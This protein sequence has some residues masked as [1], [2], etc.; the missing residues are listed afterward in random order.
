MERALKGR[1]P[2]G[3]WF[4]PRGFLSRPAVWGQRFEDD[5][6]VRENRGTFDFSSAPPFVFLE[7]TSGFAPFE[8][9]KQFRAGHHNASDWRFVKCVEKMTYAPQ[10]RLAYAE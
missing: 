9:A 6:S 2:D 5:A 10:R 1:V 7:D 3:C 8:E 4:E